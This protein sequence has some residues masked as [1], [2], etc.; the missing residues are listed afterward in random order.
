MPGYLKV[1]PTLGL[2]C[3][4]RG[5]RDGAAF[6]SSNPLL[7]GTSYIASQHRVERQRLTRWMKCDGGP[8]VIVSLQH[9]PRRAPSARRIRARKEFNTH[10]PGFDTA[11]CAS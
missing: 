10:Q 6:V 2:S 1:G 3:E 5:F 4:G 11:R 7:D 8:D 9:R